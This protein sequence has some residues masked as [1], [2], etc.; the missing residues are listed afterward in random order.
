MG[1]G[2]VL[3]H[4]L[5][6]HKTPGIYGITWALTRLPL[7]VG[8]LRLVAGI[9]FV[10][11]FLPLALALRIPFSG[12]YLAVAS[13]PAAVVLNSAIDGEKLFTEHAEGACLVLALAAA[14][15][16]YQTYSTFRRCL[17][18]AAA[19]AA[20]SAAI[21]M[22]PTALL[23]IPPLLWLATIASANR[24][25]RTTAAT[26]GAFI[27]G[28]VTGLAAVCAWLASQGVLQ[29]CFDIAI[30]G[31]MKISGRF[32]AAEILTHWAILGSRFVAVGFAFLLAGL[33]LRRLWAERKQLAVA[34][35]VLA[36]LALAEAFIPRKEFFHYM[37]PLGY[38]LVPL[39]WVSLAA[40]EL[41]GPP[42]RNPVAVAVLALAVLTLSYWNVPLA[43]NT[44]ARLAEPSSPQVYG[45][46]VSELV[47]H[48]DAS[49]TVWSADTQCGDL[50][51]Y[52]GCA[53]ATRYLFING[54]VR[55]LVRMNVLLQDLQANRPKLILV[56]PGRWLNAAGELSEN[57]PAG[58]RLYIEA[59][60]TCVQPGS[61]AASVFV[62]RKRPKHVL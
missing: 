44:V 13:L 24:N 10:A 27:L 42:R 5:W 4:D 58:L 37:L 38:I 22:R 9:L 52:T 54:D 39:G 36:L 45:V 60:Y 20:V 12:R 3:Y 25:G 17:W 46:Q 19:G 35:A 28:G 51:W 34:F 30:V 1:R 29:E 26:I 40:D 48:L 33:G 31:N 43:V 14:V 59:E 16:A 56:G 6:D 53:S 11:C 2:M 8:G 18:S 47:K 23:Y 49:D 50:Y 55:P 57:V 41:H 62:R 61:P 32:G 7:A 21:A 15:M